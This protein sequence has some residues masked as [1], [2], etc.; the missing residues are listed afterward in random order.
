MA[1]VDFRGEM[2]G[3]ADKGT[4]QIS[5]KKLRERVYCKRGLAAVE[6]PYEIDDCERHSWIGG[7]LCKDGGAV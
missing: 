1:S 7:F 5:R 6:L 2:D 4:V 3:R